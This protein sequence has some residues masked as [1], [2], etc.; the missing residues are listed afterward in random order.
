MRLNSML[1]KSRSVFII[2]SL[3][4]M[5]LGQIKAL[6]IGDIPEGI[7][8][9]FYRKPPAPSQVALPKELLKTLDQVYP[10]FRMAKKKDYCMKDLIQHL[11]LAGVNPGEKWAYGAL[12]QDFNGDKQEDYALIINYQDKFIL[13]GALKSNN[14]NQPY[15]VGTLA[16]AM[17][18]AGERTPMHEVSSK[19]CEGVLKVGPSWSFANKS[20]PSPYLGMFN[21]SSAMI[22]Y[23]Q[24]NHWIRIGYEP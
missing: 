11:Q 12:R 2:F 3:G 15:Q 4:L 14:P 7:H 6:D 20:Y 18:A 19:I 1:K 22:F 23:Y 8:S 21:A 13:V 17:V 24:D 10:G 5:F 9:H 16:P